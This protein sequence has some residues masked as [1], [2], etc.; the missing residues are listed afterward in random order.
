MA[1]E[2]TVFILYVFPVPF[3]FPSIIK[4][5][6]HPVADGNGSLDLYFYPD[7][8]LGLFLYED[9]RLIEIFRSQLLTTLNKRCKAII[10]ILFSRYG[11]KVRIN[12]QEIQHKELTTDIAI[13]DSKPVITSPY[14]SVDHPDARKASKTW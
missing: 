2:G 6:S 9:K 4:A 3:P 13:I 12:A 7:G 1:L 5:G 11:I 8:T 14:I 10:T